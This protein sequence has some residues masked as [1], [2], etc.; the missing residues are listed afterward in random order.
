MSTNGLAIPPVLL[1][2]DSIL[3]TLQILYY[4]QQIVQVRKSFPSTPTEE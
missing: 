3:F 2:S 4:K 1:T